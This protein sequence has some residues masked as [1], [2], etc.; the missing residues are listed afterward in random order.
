VK[1]LKAEMARLK[2]KLY[3][4]R[5]RWSLPASVENPKGV[6]LTKDGASLA[7]VG[8]RDG[9]VVVFK[10]LGPQIGCVS[11]FVGERVSWWAGLVV[12]GMVHPQPMA[13]VFF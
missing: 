13:L 2:P 6:V 9:G 4:A 5:Q 1:D 11:T 12:A 8:V 10:D 3:P 7:E